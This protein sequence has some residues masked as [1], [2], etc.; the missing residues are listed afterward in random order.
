MAKTG[1]FKLNPYAGGTHQNRDDRNHFFR[2]LL[3]FEKK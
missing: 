1:A 2:P 3:P